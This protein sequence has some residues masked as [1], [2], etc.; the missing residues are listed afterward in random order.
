[1]KTNVDKKYFGK[2]AKIS[3]R[4]SADEN[5]RCFFNLGDYKTNIS[6][7]QTGPGE[8]EGHYTVKRGDAAEHLQL[9]IHLKAPGGL[10]RTWYEPN[11]DI[12]IDG[13]AP[14]SPKTPQA[15]VDSQGVHLSWNFLADDDIQGFVIEKSE[16][17]VGD[18]TKLARTGETRFLDDSPAHGT[19][20]YYRIRSIDRAGNLSPVQNSLSVPMSEEAEKSREPT[21]RK[22]AERFEEWEKQF[23]KYARMGKEAFQKQ[24]FGN[25]L[26]YL[27]EALELKSDRN[28]FLYIVYTQQAMGLDTQA[29][30]T[31]EKAIRTYPYDFRFYRM[32]AKILLN[33]GE[34]QE[35]LEYVRQGIRL[36]SRDEGL[37]F[38]EKH[39]EETIK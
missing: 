4:I 36:N 39:I 17:P 29:R 26:R 32:Y 38:L 22:E 7:N 21:E 35:A 34:N 20:C 8:Y 9:E 12:I 25:A 23:Q 5:I 28:C 3:V 10:H 1:M 37:K 11:S 31:L 2:G 33:L 27:T 13:V 19:T 24:I 16:Q 14:A 6:M 18:Y 30:E 15:Q